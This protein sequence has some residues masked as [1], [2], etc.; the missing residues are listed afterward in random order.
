[1]NETPSTATLGTDTTRPARLNPHDERRVAVVAGCDPRSVRAR[2][3]G[4]RQHSTIAARVD[5]ALRALG[6]ARPEQAF[7]PPPNAA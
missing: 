7:N 5:D 6:F 3:A 2:L 4:R 1:M